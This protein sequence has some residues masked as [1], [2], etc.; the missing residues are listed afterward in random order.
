MRDL[1]V[2][3]RNAEAMHDYYRPQCQ[4]DPLQ[5]GGY[6][7]CHVVAIG[8]VDRTL[9]NPILCKPAKK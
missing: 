9:V 1:A 4:Y 6:S 3:F 7:V 8:R 5:S 2:R